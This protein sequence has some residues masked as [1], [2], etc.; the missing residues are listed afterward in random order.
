MTKQNAEK[1]LKKSDIDRAELMFTKFKIA[2]SKKILAKQSILASFEK[3][4]RLR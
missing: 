2:R 3:L 4:R 1:C